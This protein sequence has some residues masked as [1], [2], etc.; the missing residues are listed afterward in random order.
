MCKIKLNILKITA[1]DYKRI[2]S[3]KNTFKN[4]DKAVLCMCDECGGAGY[5]V[6]EAH[7][8]KDGY[9][10]NGIFCLCGG[11]NCKVD[12]VEII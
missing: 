8:D 7:I 11:R 4:L 6:S 5:V 3:Y 9:V 12:K 1:E 10:S 2:Q